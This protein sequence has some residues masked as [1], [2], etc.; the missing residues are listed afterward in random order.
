MPLRFDKEQDLWILERELPV[1]V[2]YLSESM[3]RF[4]FIFCVPEGVKA[5]DFQS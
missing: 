2:F 1:S 5:F 4:L 3:H